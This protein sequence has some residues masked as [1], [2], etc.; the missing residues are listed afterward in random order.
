LRLITDPEMLEKGAPTVDLAAPRGRAETPGEYRDTIDE[1][2]DL[3]P[4]RP[5]S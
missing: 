5:A 1:I 2:E 4:V 3:V